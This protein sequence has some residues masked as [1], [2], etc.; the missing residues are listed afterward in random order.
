[1]RLPYDKDNMSRTVFDVDK[2]KLKKNEVARIILIEESADCAYSHFVDEK[3]Y[4]ICVGKLEVLK[5]QGADA[6][7]CLLCKHALQGGPIASARRHFVTQVVRYTTNSRGELLDPISV[8]VIPW[9]FGDDKFND[10]TLKKQVHGDLRKK[11]LVIKCTKEAYQQFQIEVAEPIW[12]KTEAMKNKVIEVF[13]ERKLPDI[14][15]ALGRNINTEQMAKLI[16]DVTATP[17]KRESSAEAA[18]AEV[19]GDVQKEVAGK[20][21]ATVD[22]DGDKELGELLGTL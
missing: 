12:L 8:D 7:S 4:F 5:E 14:E 2:L 18:Q 20:E 10:L 1:M 15:K 19:V 11:D 17:T 21:G 3:G 13:K 6:D 22:F 16:E 9:V